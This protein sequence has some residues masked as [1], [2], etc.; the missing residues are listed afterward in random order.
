[1]PSTLIELEDDHVGDGAEDKE[2]EE[3]GGD[4]N[5]GVDGGQSAQACGRGSIWGFGIEAGGCGLTKRDQISAL[6]VQEEVV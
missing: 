5:I 6:R 3:D 4:G 2:E 1:M